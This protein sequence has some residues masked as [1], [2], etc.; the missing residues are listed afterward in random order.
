MKKIY[1]Q[2]FKIRH[3]NFPY[4][5]ENA[6]TVSW[7]IEGDL[8]MIKI[9]WHKYVGLY[10]PDGKPLSIW[11][12]FGPPIFNGKY[13]DTEKIVLEDEYMRYT[14][15]MMMDHAVLLPE[16]KTKVDDGAARSFSL[17]KQLIGPVPTIGWKAA[18]AAVMN[19][20]KTIDQT[21]LDEYDPPK[22]N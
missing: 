3:W 19:R 20:N 22:N 15:I 5:T 8:A 10:C 17:N 6:A 16:F 13:L 7:Y 21:V 9:K 14:L 12:D 4:E 1:D 18:P 11:M 2:I